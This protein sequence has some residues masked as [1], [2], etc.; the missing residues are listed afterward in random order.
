[1]TGELLS[2]ENSVFLKAQTDQAVIETTPQNENLLKGKKILITGASSGTGLLTA[3]FASQQGATTYLGTRNEDNFAKAL[4]NITNPD[5]TFMFQADISQP[6][7][8]SHTLDAIGSMPDVIIHS[9]AAGMDFM[10]DFLRGLISILT[11]P[12]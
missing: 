8:V 3:D 10:P 5:N 9:A 1:M 4:R 6:D 2:F 11:C 12:N 7:Q